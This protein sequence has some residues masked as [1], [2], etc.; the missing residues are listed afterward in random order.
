VSHGVEG[1]RN[2]YESEMGDLLMR[3]KNLLQRGV[4]RVSVEFCMVKPDWCY[5]G[6]E[7]QVR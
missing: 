5:L 4:R 1:C 7:L 3:E 6:S 2:I